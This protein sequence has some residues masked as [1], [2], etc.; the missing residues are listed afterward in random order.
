MIT[1]RQTNVHFPKYGYKYYSSTT[2]PCPKS[3][4]NSPV[5]AAIPAQE[6]EDTYKVHV[7][8]VGTEKFST[9]IKG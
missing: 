6:E 1:I 4:A 8:I 5:V 3:F 9:T 2:S 7:A